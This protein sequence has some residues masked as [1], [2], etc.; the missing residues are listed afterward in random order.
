MCVDYAEIILAAQT[1]RVEG[2]D[3]SSRIRVMRTLGVCRCKT[4]PEVM[5]FAFVDG[6]QYHVCRA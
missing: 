3:S 6:R 2:E 5:M 1:M 4:E